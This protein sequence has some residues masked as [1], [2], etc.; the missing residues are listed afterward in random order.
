MNCDGVADRFE[1]PL[2]RVSERPAEA[3]HEPARFFVAAE[4][5]R[6]II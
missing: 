1:R 6:L 5:Q 3:Q 2:S 4:P